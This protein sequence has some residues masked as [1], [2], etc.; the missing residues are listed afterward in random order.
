MAK[1]NGALSKDPTKKKQSQ[2]PTKQENLAIYNQMPPEMQAKYRQLRANKGG[3]AALKMLQNFQQGQPQAPTPE[4]IT[5]EGF[6]GA[7]GAY[8]DMME[9]FRGEINTPP[10][11]F[12]QEMERARQNVMGQFDRRNQR[13]FEQQ[14]T[15]VQ[16]QIAERGL[17]PASPA[18]QELM[19]QQNERED[20]ARQEALSS[21]EQ[22]AYGIQQQGFGQSQSLAMRPYE[23][24]GI[25]QQPYMAGITAQYQ[26]RQQQQQQ[27]W[28]AK[29]NQLQR[30]SAENI[31]RMARSGGGGG[32]PGPTL[33]DRY[34]AER[35]GTGYDTQPQPNPWAVGVG[36]FVNAA[37]NQIINRR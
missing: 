36:S 28:E 35:L 33:F 26:Q 37:G 5:E 6:I 8:N 29:Q 9:R 11:S 23:Q 27:G 1:N 14:R 3:P 7:G 2:V 19:R 30:Q 32:Q 24:W 16:Q 15:S 21:A 13:Q 12:D 17:D 18:A 34:E 31:A 25:L 22:A 20:M 4:Q 10:P